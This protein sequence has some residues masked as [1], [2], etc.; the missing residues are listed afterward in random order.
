MNF[1]DLAF[2]RVLLDLRLKQVLVIS[3]TNALVGCVASVSFL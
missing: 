2:I 3:T 1:N